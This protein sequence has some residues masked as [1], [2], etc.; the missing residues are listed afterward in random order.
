ME[1]LMSQQSWLI[2]GVED[3]DYVVVVLS[4]DDEF[5]VAYLLSKN[6]YLYNM[7]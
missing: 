4:H 1:L 6:C 3:G 7:L 2:Y 5:K